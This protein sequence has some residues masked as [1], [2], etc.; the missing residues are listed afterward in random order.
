MDLFRAILLSI[1]EEPSGKYWNA[2]PLLN[3]SIQDVVAHVRLIDDAGLIE[4]RFLGNI[5]NDGAFVIRMTNA[6]YDFLEESRQPTRWEQA[7]AQL[8]AAGLPTTIAVIKTVL[9]SLVK[10]HLPY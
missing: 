1:E 7:K 2:K 3:H 9:E 8:K 6:G 5:D 4:A 10:A